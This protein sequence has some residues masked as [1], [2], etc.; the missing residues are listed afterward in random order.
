MAQ[1]LNELH[2][3]LKETIGGLPIKNHLK[4]LFQ[5]LNDDTWRQNPTSPEKKLSST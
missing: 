5:S 3:I 2:S 1:E 4:G